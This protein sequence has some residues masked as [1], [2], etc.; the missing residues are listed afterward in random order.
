MTGGANSKFFSR[1]VVVALVALAF[2]GCAAMLA[3]GDKSLFADD[4]YT[5]LAR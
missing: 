2:A 4:S 1:I 3:G 5:D